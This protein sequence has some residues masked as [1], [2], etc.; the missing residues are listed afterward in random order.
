MAFLGREHVITE[1][2]RKAKE[3]LL[4][5]QARNPAPD[6]VGLLRQKA[7]LAELEQKLAAL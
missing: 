2:I 6:D 3:A 5:I 1:N 7:K 4:F